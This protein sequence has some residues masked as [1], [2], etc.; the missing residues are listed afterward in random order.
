MFKVQHRAGN[1]VVDTTGDPYGESFWKSIESREYEPDTVG[2]LEHNLD[3]NS[4]LMDIGAANGAMT[5]IAANLGSQV[6]SYEPDPTM[7]AI[8]KRNIELNKELSERITIINSGIS[9]SQGKIEF[10]SKT[11]NSIFSSIVVGNNKESGSLIEIRSLQEELSRI[12]I[13]NNSQ[14]VVKMDIEGAEWRIL[15]DESVL[16]ALKAKKVIL[17]LAVHPGFYRPHEKIIKG[18]D[19]LLLLFWHYRNYLESLRTFKLLS[20]Y[21]SV[22]RTNLNPIKNARNFGVLV[23]G[24]YHEFILKF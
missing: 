5:M 22:Q 16:K 10:S 21:S 18:L 2:F 4:I 23:L 11:D 24:G 3:A 17:L 9:N 15:N 14:I 20:K 7:F 13:Q 1:F 12:E 6:I 19:R 8:L